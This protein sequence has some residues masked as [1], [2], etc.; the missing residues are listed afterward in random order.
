MSEVTSLSAI[1]NRST[2][3]VEGPRK[4]LA[5]DNLYSAVTDALS[6]AAHNAV[7][8]Q[9]Q[10]SV[11]QQAATT[12]C[13]AM[14]YSLDFASTEA[15]TNNAHQNDATD[16]VVRSQKDDVPAELSDSIQTE[17]GEG[18]LSSGGQDIPMEIDAL[19]ASFGRALTVISQAQLH[20][21]NGVVKQALEAAFL[22]KVIESPEKYLPYLDNIFGKIKQI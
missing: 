3:D 7:F 12:Q 17:L 14:I 11:L 16:S 10:F 18:T 4:K 8:A 5:I 6:L 1:T 2:G 15:A 19:M 13:V 9:Q 20:S 22:L 21:S